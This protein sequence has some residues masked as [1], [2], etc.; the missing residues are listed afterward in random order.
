MNFTSLNL[1]T[2][3]MSD[4]ISVRSQVCSIQ[5]GSWANNR[6]GTELRTVN[7]LYKSSHEILKFIQ[8]ISPPAALLLL[9]L[10]CYSPVWSLK[11]PYNP[12]NMGRTAL[13]WQVPLDRF[14][15]LGLELFKGLQALVPNDQWC[16]FGSCCTAGPTRSWIFIGL[17]APAPVSNQILEMC[18]RKNPG[19][20]RLLC[21]LA[22]PQ[23]NA[24]SNQ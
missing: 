7:T 22:I 5:T 16:C 24:W 17:V 8:E 12:N 18:T 13:C 23:E 2:P 4:C 21:T 6:L 3:F 1:S 19:L 11:K 20:F 14:V 9:E 10:S 15:L